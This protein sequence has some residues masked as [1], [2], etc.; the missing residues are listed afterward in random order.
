MSRIKDVN[1][2]KPHRFIKRNQV[3]DQRSRLEATEKKQADTESKQRPGNGREGMVA[4]LV[5]SVGVHKSEQQ[6]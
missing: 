5:L 1:C 6:S 3:A 4:K 2:R